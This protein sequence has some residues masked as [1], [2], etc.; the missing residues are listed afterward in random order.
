MLETKVR[1]RIYAFSATR[2][3]KP[4]AV[5]SCEVVTASIGSAPLLGNS[6]GIAV[7]GSMA[8]VSAAAVTFE[9]RVDVR[10][11]VPFVAVALVEFPEP[12]VN[13]NRIASPVLVDVVDV[14]GEVVVVWA[15]APVA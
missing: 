11:L 2:P 10:V 8:F 9:A 13:V 4:A 12:G 7:D 14:R 3:S 6:D 15:Q 5:T 1:N